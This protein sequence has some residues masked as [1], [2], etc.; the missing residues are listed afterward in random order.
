L[1]PTTQKELVVTDQV[2]YSNAL[3]VEQAIKGAAKTAHKADPSRQISDLI[4]QAY[5]DRFLCRVFSDG[6]ATEWVLKGGSGML[7]RVA[8]AR[9][10]LDVDL[11]RN[12]YSKDQGLADLR[13]LAEI[14]LGDFFRFVLI[15]HSDTI[16]EETQ[17]Y[18]DGYQVLFD[19][20]LGVKKVDNLKVDLSAHETAL[21]LPQAMD[22]ANRLA[23]PRLV[24]N[25]YRLY[26]LP[27]QIADKVCASLTIYNGRPSSREKDLVD[28]VVIALTQ[29]VDARDA[30]DALQH[31]AKIRHLTLP[32]AFLL[33][34]TWGASYVKLAKN[35]PAADYGIID[36]QALMT[37]FI[38]PLLAGTVMSMIWNPNQLS[39]V[40]LEI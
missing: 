28:L 21:D 8:N 2:P 31:E 12:G 38:D 33:P 32:E 20:Y 18:T 9:R 39:W 25:P 5:Y 15:S 6:D 16:A 35:T 22:P 23:L 10:T 37:M 36:A 27:Q 26:P 19:V 13:R 11:F 30:Q 14:D 34:A 24:S 40:S 7:A 4:R 1:S 17:P 3:A 29:T